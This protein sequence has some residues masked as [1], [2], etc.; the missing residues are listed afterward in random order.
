M[1]ISNLLQIPL[2]MVVVVLCVINFITLT[3]YGYDKYC[4]IKD[5]PRI[6][7]ATLLLWA[8]LGGAL[9]AIVG[10]VLFRHKTHHWKFILLVPLLLFVQALGLTYTLTRLGYI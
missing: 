10:M 1:N 8:L 9:G 2:Q 3:L 6:R 4:A 5:K 7:E